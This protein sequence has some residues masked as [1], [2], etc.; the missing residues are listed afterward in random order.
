MDKMKSAF[1][2]A[3]ERAGGIPELTPEQAREIHERPYRAAGQALARRYL[4]G[5]LAPQ[6]LEPELRRQPDTGRGVARRALLQ[7]LTAGMTLENTPQVLA[8]I[9]AQAGSPAVERWCGE[10]EKAYHHYQRQLESE[11]RR[12]EGNFARQARQ[13]LEREGIRGSA[14]KG[15]PFRQSPAYRQLAAR[16]EAEYRPAVE[17]FASFLE[18]EVGEE[19]GGR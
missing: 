13:V 8:A 2:I 7:A 4:T 15:F 11:S 19:N 9:R 5:E 16:F 12:L 17:Q 14:I 3:L 18:K 1:E 6:E 10:L